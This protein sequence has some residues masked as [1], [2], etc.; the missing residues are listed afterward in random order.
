MRCKVVRGILTGTR[1]LFSLLTYFM[2]CFNGRIFHFGCFESAQLLFPVA[3]IMHLYNLKE[4]SSV[5]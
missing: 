4:N 5:E 3:F 1:N 2:D